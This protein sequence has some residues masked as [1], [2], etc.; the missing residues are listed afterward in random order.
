VLIFTQNRQVILSL[1]TEIYLPGDRMVVGGNL[2]FI[3]YPNTYW[4]IG[5]D[6]PDEGEE[7]Y[8]RRFVNLEVEITR[9]YGASLQVGG[10]AVNEVG[11]VTETAAGG[12]LEAAG[13]SGAGPQTLVG[14][15]GVVQWDSRDNLFYPHRGGY[16][17]LTWT[18]FGSGFG[19]DVGFSEFSL[20]MRRFLTVGPGQVA[21]MQIVFRSA[22]GSV[23]FY[24]LAELGGQN[25]M[26]GYFEGRYRDH[27]SVVAQLEYRI[28]LP[29]RLG[30]V[31]F[32]GLGDVAPRM[33]DLSLSESKP[34]YGA[35]LRWSL[36]EQERQNLRL[37]FG[38]G[39]DTSGFY[40]TFAEAF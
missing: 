21:G 23:P 35:G 9:R 38:F 17:R 7:D 12:M 20:D 32:G 34:S 14:L 5:R 37:D 26:R 2:T 1:G 24:R 3:D 6:V 31:A 8:T 19:S 25:V 15:G 16:Y 36:N 40:I 29:G 18:G 28:D 30:V 33:A 22:D 10:R 4:G 27:A 39:K 13:F 11:E